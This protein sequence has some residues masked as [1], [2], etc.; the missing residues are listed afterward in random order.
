[1]FV[2]KVDMGNRDRN[3][4]SS[5][6]CVCIWLSNMCVLSLGS[7]D[8]GVRF[9]LG[10]PKTCLY[11]EGSLDGGCIYGEVGTSVQ[12]TCSSC[13]SSPLWCR[14]HLHPRCRRRRRSAPPGRRSSRPRR[15]SRCISVETAKENTNTPFSNT[16]LIIPGFYLLMMLPGNTAVKPSQTASTLAPLYQPH[17]LTS[18]P[19]FSALLIITHAIEPENSSGSIL[20]STTPPGLHKSFH[21]TLVFQV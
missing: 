3:E 14:P 21:M 18:L 4:W 9:R 19:C 15:R 11:R 1:M 20:L 13:C 8:G 10:L 5:N 2:I 7:I 16:G 6:M 12:L 17:Q